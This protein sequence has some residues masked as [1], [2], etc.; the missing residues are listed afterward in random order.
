MTMSLMS[1]FTNIDKAGT[2]IMTISLPITIL[3]IGTIGNDCVVT[4]VFV[5]NIREAVS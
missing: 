3:V 4:I 5:I 2:D 1:I